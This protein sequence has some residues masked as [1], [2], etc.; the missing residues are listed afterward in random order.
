MRNIKLKLIIGLVA[1]GGLALDALSDFLSH[2]DDEERM[3]EIAREVYR[4]EEG[5]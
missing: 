2:K 3:R 4:E 5:E 1:I